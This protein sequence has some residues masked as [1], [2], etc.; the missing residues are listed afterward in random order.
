MKLSLK[1]VKVIIEFLSSSGQGLEVVNDLLIVSPKE[2]HFSY[3]DLVYD[4]VVLEKKA[5][6]SDLSVIFSSDAYN[7][8]IALRKEG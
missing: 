3:T 5:D 6:L 8:V 4:C 7:L 2:W 1:Y